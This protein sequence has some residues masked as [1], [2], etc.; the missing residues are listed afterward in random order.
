MF[1]VFLPS[2]STINKNK[3]LASL[4]AY[5]TLGVHTITCLNICR[6]PTKRAITTPVFSYVK[7]CKYFFLEERKQNAI[8][9]ST[10]ASTIVISKHKAKE[11]YTIYPVR[12]F[13]PLTYSN[14]SLF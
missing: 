7:A 8:G 5:N 13:F 2:S 1:R 14:Y 11:N 6:E 4:L 3:D 9:P 10:C 12:I